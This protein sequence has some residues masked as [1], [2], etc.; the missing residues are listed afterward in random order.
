MKNYTGAEIQATVK[1]ASSFAFQ[2]INSIFDFDKKA[3][4][5][6]EEFRVGPNDF[7]AALEEVRP[8]FGIDNS[9]FDVFLRKPLID[10]GKPF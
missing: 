5:K 4:T 6:Q 10:Y 7:D 2:R 3:S 9:K 1:S 8:Q